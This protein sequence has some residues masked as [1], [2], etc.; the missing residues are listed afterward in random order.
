MASKR[1]WITV[2]WLAAAVLAVLGCLFQLVGLVTPAWVYLSGQG[3]HP[4]SYTGYDLQTGLWFRYKCDLVDCRRIS[5]GE[6]NLSDPPNLSSNQALALFSF[7]LT[8][9]GVVSVVISRACWGRA[10]VRVTSLIAA[11]FL[12]I[13]SFILGLVPTIRMIGEN[14]Q[15]SGELADRFNGMTYQVVV[16]S[17]YSLALFGFG[18]LL[19][20]FAAIPVLL[21]CIINRKTDLDDDYD[22]GGKSYN[23][24][25]FPVRE[26]QFEPAPARNV[27]SEYKGDPYYE[28]E[29]AASKWDR[30][31]RGR[32]DR[33]DRTRSE[34]SSRYAVDL[35]DKPR[36]R[37]GHGHSHARS[38]GRGYDDDDYEDYDTGESDRESYAKMEIGEKHGR[39]TT[40]S[41]S[42]KHYNSSMV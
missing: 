3:T 39:G 10:K 14:Q 38:R 13:L 36:H 32:E 16:R 24:N 7:L 15:L 5:F 41:V 34:P 21:N 31:K 33:S 11:T 28:P 9:V 30:S 22:Y 35:P 42:N 26:K 29:T 23:A 20:G 4:Q 19:V 37:E 27:H 25:A 6:D 8:V 18:S 12:L 17:P 1:V 2:L 40:R